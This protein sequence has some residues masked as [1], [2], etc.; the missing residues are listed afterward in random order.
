MAGRAVPPLGC[1]LTLGVQCGRFMSERGAGGTDPKG[2]DDLP[3]SP[4]H[5]RVWRVTDSIVMQAFMG[6]GQRRRRVATDRSTN[7]S[8][9]AKPKSTFA[10]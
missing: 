3:H 1:H 5:Q 9:A 6:K 8:S 10:Q 4:L 2:A 7:P